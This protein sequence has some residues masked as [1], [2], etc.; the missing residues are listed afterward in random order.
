MLWDS[1]LSGE[2]WLGWVYKKKRESLYRYSSHVLRLWNAIR[3]ETSS[4]ASRIMCKSINE[5]TP[6]RHP[7]LLHL[8]AIEIFQ[9]SE[10]QM[11]ADKRFYV[12]LPNPAS[13][14]KLLD[15]DFSCKYTIMGEQSKGFPEKFCNI[16]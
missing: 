4:R 14:L 6:G 8:T 7:S 15:W 5:Y 10:R 16:P 11:S 3:N 2:D 1:P 9:I 13:L 12:M